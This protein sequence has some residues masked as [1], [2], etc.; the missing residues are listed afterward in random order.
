MRE[1]VQYFP[2]SS[3]S[4]VMG[5][6]GLTIVFGKF[7]HLQM[8]SKLFYDISIF[9]VLALFLLFIVLYSFKVV[10]YPQEVRSDFNHRIRINFL[11]TI[12]ISILLLATAF[13]TYYPLLAISLWW[14]GV[15]LH[16]FFTFKILNFWIVK[17]FDIKLFNP[18]WFIPI[19][20]N[21]LI[22]ISGVDFAPIIVS[23]FY[24]TAGL[25]FWIV[26]FVLFFY[27]TIFHD[28]IPEKFIPTF[29]ILLAPPSIG[30]VSYMRI[31]GSWDN[32]SV[33][34]LLLSYF[35]IILLLSMSK[36]FSGLKFYMSWWAFTFPLT[37]VTVA[38]LVAFQVTQDFAYMFISWLML[39]LSFGAIS[40]VAWQTIR[41][42]I[43]GEICVE[44]D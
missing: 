21:L 5:L 15:I 26:L 13:Y 34:L 18:A 35:F 20:G 30:F 9:A 24:F 17:D 29:F 22:P 44:E 14:A 42:I 10:M 37:A 33:F 31:T 23:Y 39:G 38:S 6:T 12:S 40:V 1:K 7:Y 3:F 28:H 11:A 16:T 41:H 25:F 27:R 43:K 2:I 8:L 4:A 36:R 19:V 32:F